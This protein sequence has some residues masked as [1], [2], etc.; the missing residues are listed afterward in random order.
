M[1]KNKVFGQA[2]GGCTTI[3][4]KK[5]KIYQFW[6]KITKKSRI[7]NTACVNVFT[8]KS[9][10]GCF[11]FGEKRRENE[12]FRQSVFKGRITTIFI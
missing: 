3:E 8:K 6:H 4:I 1:P 9:K 10:R 5:K 2:G 7:G 12:R 11:I